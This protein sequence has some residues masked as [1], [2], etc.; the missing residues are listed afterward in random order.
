MNF[1]EKILN[2]KF[3]FKEAVEDW[4]QKEHPPLS[5]EI[6][7]FYASREG[8]E[9]TEEDKDILRQIVFRAYRNHGFI[10]AQPTRVGNW[11]H[12]VIN[13]RLSK[14]G[15]PY[16]INLTNNGWLLNFI[17]KATKEKGEKHEEN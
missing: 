16:E 6:D 1:Y 3:T 5:S 15:L 11:Q 2:K 4:F 13:T 17:P 8:C 7:L 12:T 9:L 14:M 10:E